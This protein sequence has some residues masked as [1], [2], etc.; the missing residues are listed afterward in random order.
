MAKFAELLDLEVPVLINFYTDKDEEKTG[1][2]EVLSAVAEEFEAHTKVVK[3]NVN[4][5]RKLS[6]A[7]KIDSVPTLMIYKKGK[8]VWR[9]KGAKEAKELISVLKNHL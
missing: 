4:E 2:D 8:M 7:L 3:I 5:N 1:L 6:N 9:H